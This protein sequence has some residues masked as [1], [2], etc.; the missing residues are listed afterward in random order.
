MILKSELK[1]TF[2]DEEM[3]QESME[4]HLKKLAIITTLNKA[5]F[6]SCG[7]NDKCPP[8]SIKADKITHDKD[9]KKIIY[10]KS[11]LKIYDLPVFIFL[12]FFI[13]IRQ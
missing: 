10:D 13:L 4:F 11:I 2:E 12:N 9:K 8:W 7:L 3:I 6:T 5:I 1:D